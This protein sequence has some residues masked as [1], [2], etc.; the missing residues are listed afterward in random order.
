MKTTEK[1]TSRMLEVVN[2]LKSKK[3][4]LKE[5]CFLL[6]IEYNPAS[7][8]ALL[9]D[10]KDLRDKGHVIEADN[11]RPQHYELKSSPPPALRADEALAIHIALRLLYHHTKNPPRSYFNALEKITPQMPTELRHIAQMSLPTQSMNDEK[12]SQFEKGTPQ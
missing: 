4:T 5:L 1:K 2:I 6:G 12:L 8:Q 10:F 11:K 3:R 9:R 7:H